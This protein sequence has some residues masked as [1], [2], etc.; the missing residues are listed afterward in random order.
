MG[1]TVVCFVTAIVWLC[2]RDGYS[3]ERKHHP[4]PERVITV[5]GLPVCD[6]GIVAK[7]K[8]VSEADAARK[9]L[10]Y[11][12]VCLLLGEYHH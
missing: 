3:V 12:A 6:S 9:Y 11:K 8:S 10:P 4:S 5:T 1:A 7:S 2:T